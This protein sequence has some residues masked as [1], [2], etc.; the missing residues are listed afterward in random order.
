MGVPNQIRIVT[1]GSDVFA[2]DT[3]RWPEDTF[4]YPIVYLACSMAEG[5]YDANRIGWKWINQA[6]FEWLALHK[7]CMVS[8]TG[9]IP[10]KFYCHNHEC[11]E[12]AG[13]DWTPLLIVDEPGYVEP[14]LDE[15][16]I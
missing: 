4:Q 7:E 13:K 11:W 6:E 10:M 8:Y 1:S 9:T 5:S 14:N 12:R 3:I 15:R 16:K 2:C